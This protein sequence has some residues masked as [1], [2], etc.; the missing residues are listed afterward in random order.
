MA[1][2]SLYLQIK[3]ETIHMKVIFFIGFTDVTVKTIHNQRAPDTLI[4]NIYSET[5]NQTI[6]WVLFSF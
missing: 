6:V 3:R 2:V 1:K 5:A 4:S